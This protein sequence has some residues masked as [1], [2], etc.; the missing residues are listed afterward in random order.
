MTRLIFLLF[1]T[2][3]AIA[4]VAQTPQSSAAPFSISISMVNSQVSLGSPTKIQIVLENISD[5]EITVAESNFSKNG[6]RSY[7]LNVVSNTGSAVPRT[8]YGKALSGQRTQSFTIIRDSQKPHFLQPHEKLV[9]EAT[10]NRIYKFENPGTFF[11]QAAKDIN[12][13]A[14]NSDVVKSNILTVT[15]VQDAKSQ[16]K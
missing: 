12:P 1:T 14:A 3:V 10:L 2:L 7:R 15:I 8:D 13:D 9:S 4:A 5:K 11:V 6:E 16:N